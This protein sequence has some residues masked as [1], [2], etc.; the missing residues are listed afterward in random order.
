MLVMV[1][2]L[3]LNLSANSRSSR[4]KTATVPP[5]ITIGQCPPLSLCLVSP[6]SPERHCSQ[7]HFNPGITRSLPGALSWHSYLEQSACHLCYM[8]QSVD[9]N[10]PTALWVCSVDP[11][12]IRG[13]VNKGSVNKMSVCCPSLLDKLLQFVIVR[14]LASNLCQ[15]S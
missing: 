8:A 5:E 13:L 12:A 4:F 6:H 2:C 1:C 3:P 9:I 10:L 11:A 7:L 14:P 15:I